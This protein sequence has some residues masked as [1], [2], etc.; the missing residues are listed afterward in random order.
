MKIKLSEFKNLCQLNRSDWKRETENGFDNDNA[1]QNTVIFL[2][3]FWRIW[4]LKIWIQISK[5]KTNRRISKQNLSIFPLQKEVWNKK[6]CQQKSKKKW[7]QSIGFKFG[8]LFSRCYK[9]IFY[10]LARTTFFILITVGSQ[11]RAFFGLGLV[12]WH[13]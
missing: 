11:I 3:N 7:T 4:F 10:G 6:S 9:V 13:C 8:G 1:M 12:L 5:I 2:G